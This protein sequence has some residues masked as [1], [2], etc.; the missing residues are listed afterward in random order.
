MNTVWRI[1][2][3]WGPNGETVAL[4]DAQSDTI[5]ASPTTVTPAGNGLDIAVA[6]RLVVTFPPC[7]RVWV[8]STPSFEPPDDVSPLFLPL[9]RQ[10]NAASGTM[11]VDMALVDGFLVLD[12][13][14]PEG[15]RC[16]VTLELEDIT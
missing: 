1:E 2:W 6:A 10:V 9:L 5:A 14:P 11:G 13:N 3:T 16:R 4:D 12:T 15:S 7:A 8:L